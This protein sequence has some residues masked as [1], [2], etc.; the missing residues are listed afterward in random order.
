MNGLFVFG[1]IFLVIV[2][3]VYPKLTKEV[4]DGSC[5]QAYEDVEKNKKAVKWCLI[6]SIAMIVAGALMMIF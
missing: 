1:L 4:E 6:A 3:C 2:L 5:H